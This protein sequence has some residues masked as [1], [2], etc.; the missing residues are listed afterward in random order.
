MSTLTLNDSNLKTRAKKGGIVVLIFMIIQM[1]ISIFT[2][3]VLARFV[4]PEE[5]GK[6]ALATFITGI[7]GLL[8]SSQGDVYIIQA[9]EKIKEKIN[10]IITFELILAVAFV[11]IVFFI[12]PIITKLMGRED[13][14]YIVR[15]I[16]LSFLIVPFQRVRSGL[17]KNILMF[18]SKLSA[19]VSQVIGSI[20]VVTLA[21][22][23]FG[24]YALIVWIITIPV[25]D[26]I[27]L[28]I[29]TKFKIVFNLSKS[30][31]IDVY[32]FTYP[33]IGS[34]I[35]VYFVWNVDYYIVGYY[36]SYTELG[37]YWMAFQ[38]S[39]YL[40]QAKSAINSVLIPTFAHPKSNVEKYS[41]FNLITK[42]TA[43]I[44]TLPALIILIWGKYF[45]ILIY[46]SKWLPA[47]V[48]L[49]IFLVIVVIKAIGGNAGPL[50][51]SLR[52]TKQD[53]K[54]ALI[55]AITLPIFVVIGTYYEGITGAALGVLIS[56]GINALYGFTK[57]IKPE[58]KK[59]FYF[60]YHKTVLLL[61]FIWVVLLIKNNIFAIDNLYF[62]FIFFSI[63]ILI[64]ILF[65]RKELARIANIVIANLK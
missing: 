64:Y 1:G 41:M 14:T 29:I 31:I 21:I 3:M 5:F 19:L 9:K 22:Y 35:L 4:E 38:S 39:H 12:T 8:I 11:T 46:S 53:F 58:T 51:Y 28:L 55:S 54:L 47:L 32:T 15:W 49:K 16:S 36:R 45:I 59:S 52:K 62:D 50:L 13:L 44:Y 37:Y 48:P 23:G 18:R 27:A 33:I 65:F 6:L 60:Y 20:V 7:Y 42:L 43:A 34:S 63:S 61:S 24:I 17:E 25:I 26:V 2:Q 10:V 56:A 30:V 40:F 57:Y